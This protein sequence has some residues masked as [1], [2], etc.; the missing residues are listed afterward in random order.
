M[1]LGQD[2]MLQGQ[3]QMLLGQ[4]RGGRAPASL[5]QASRATLGQA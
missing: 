4:A 2:Q 1:L 3:A 5:G